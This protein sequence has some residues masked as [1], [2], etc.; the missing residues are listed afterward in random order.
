MRTDKFDQG[1]FEWVG[2]AHN[3]PIFVST[4]IENDPIVGKEVHGIAKC[5]L[6]IRRR[7]PISSGGEG[8]A[9]SRL[10]VVFRHL[11]VRGASRLDEDLAFAGM[12]R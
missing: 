5:P 6:Q 2:E 4:N 11:V 8:R 9:P 12:V 3:Q 7:F 1:A 10:R